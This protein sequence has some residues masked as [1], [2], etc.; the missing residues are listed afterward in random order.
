MFRA[1]VVVAATGYY[2]VPRVLQVPGSTLPHVITSKALDRQDLH[3]RQIAQ[4]VLVVGGGVSALEIAA[5]LLDESN[6]SGAE[7]VDLSYRGQQFVSRWH[8]SSAPCIA[9]SAPAIQKVAPSNVH[10]SP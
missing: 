4:R 8:H 5:G 7:T 3:T 6:P 9:G 1:S 2:S 10:K